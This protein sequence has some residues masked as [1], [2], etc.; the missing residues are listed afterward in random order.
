VLD[1][2][3]CAANNLGQDAGSEVGDAVEQGD[4]ADEAQ[5]GTRTAS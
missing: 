2:G 3:L 4:E 1:Q 5:A